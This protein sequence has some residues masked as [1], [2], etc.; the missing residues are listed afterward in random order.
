MTELVHRSMKQI[1]VT[2]ILLGWHTCLIFS[3]IYPSND[4]E[5]MQHPEKEGWN[6]TQLENIGQY[7]I[8][9]S[10]LTGLMV[11]QKGKVVGSYGDVEETSYIASCRKSVLAMIY[12]PHVMAGTIQLDKTLEELGMDDVEGLS[13]EEKQATVRHLIQAR[14][15]IY[16]PAS[17]GGDFLDMAPERGTKKPGEYWLYSNWDFNAAGYIFEQETGTNIYEEV[18][19]ILVSPLGMQDWKRSE[20]QKSGNTS[21]SRY[22]AYHM[23]FSTRDM[24]RLGYL[25]LRN[26][27]WQDQQILD[28][29]WVKE[30]TT[31]YSTAE[32][33]NANVPYFGKEGYDYGYGYMWWL[34]PDNKH[35]NLKGGYSALGA[36]GQSI[37]VF[38]A[39]DVVVAFKT[40]S[41]YQRAT[42]GRVRYEISHRIA[43][44]YKG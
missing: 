21:R 5:E 13:K 8:D 38:P 16:H 36:W 26:G 9:S 43:K 6:M 24:A 41:V 33:L 18:E 1:L 22:R 44:A 12:G 4:W 14:S 11:I 3:Q 2:T 37:T 40:K 20:Q 34:W 25:M 32:E 7:I 23:W 30:M 39:I 31:F 10:Q 27:K 29:D 42:S 15:G 17:N 28:P 35:P 19:R